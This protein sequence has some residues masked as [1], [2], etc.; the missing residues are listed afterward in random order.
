MK[1]AW[2]GCLFWGGL[3]IA[4]NQSPETNV[5]SRY[6]VESVEFSGASES[7]ISTGLRKEIAELIG[8]RLNPSS[9][10]DLARRIR[11]ELHVRSVSHHV[12]RGDQPEHVKVVFEIKGRPRTFE[13]AIPKFLY[14]PKQGWSAAAE[15]TV[16]L[17]DNRMTA[18]VV[19]D[20]DELAERF[21]G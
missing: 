20:G 10:D 18:G 11:R 4:G 13:V 8:E 1:V 3:L 9:L 5:N 2:F 12:L 14:H 6:T 19:S 15:G 16:E 21:A 17:G 7:R